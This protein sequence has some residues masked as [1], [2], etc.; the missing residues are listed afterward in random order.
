MRADTPKGFNPAALEVIDFLGGDRSTGMCFC[1][2]HDDGEKASLQVNNGDR[3]PVV[4]HCWGI[5]TKEH[6]LEVIAYLKAN[7]KWPTSS[8]LSRDQSSSQAEKARSPKKRRRYALQIWKE[9]RR[10]QR[11][12]DLRH[13]L[14]GYLQRRGIKNVPETALAVVPMECHEAEVA[15][16]DPGM[17][18]PVRNNEG[19]FQGIHVVWL[20]ADM[21]AKREAKP[22]RQSYG[23]LKGNFIQLTKIDWDNPPPKLIIAEGPETALAMTQFTGLPA[24]A[25][26]GKG[27]FAAVEPPR[28]SEYIIGVDNDDDGGSRK[29]AGE[30]AQRLVGCVVRIAM[31]DKPE[32]GKNGYD[33]ND[34]LID[35][36]A[37]EGKLA[38]LARSI[39]EAPSFEA[40]MTEVE[41]REGCINALAALK[42]ED[43]LAYEQERQQAANSLKI[44]LSIL[45]E[46]VDRRVSALKAQQ[47]TSPPSFNIDL[48][49]VSAREIIASEDVLAL[50][51]KEI[52]RLIVGEEKNAKILYLVATSRLFDKTM[53]A[54]VKGPSSGGKSEIRKRVL[55]FFPPEHVI[56]FTALSEHALLYMADDFAHKVLSM[57]EA[58]TGKQVEFQDYLLRELMS[59]G[60]LRYPVVQ[61]I[62]DELVTTMIEKDGPVSFLVTTTRNKLNPEN[63]TRMLSLEVNDTEEQTKAIL[64][65]VAAVVGLNKKA[66][67][68][69]LCR[70]HDYQRWLAAGECRVFIPYA[71]T[72][73]TLIKVTKSVRLRRDFSQLLIAIK[74]HALLHREHR[75]RSTKGSIVATIEE[76]YSA[77]RALMADLL[78]TASE[79]KMR[80]TIEDTIAAVRRVAA[81]RP[82]PD[83]DGA[84]VRQV[85]KEL[86]LDRSAV[87]RRLK[88][89]EGDGHIVNLESRK[90]YPARYK[91]S[92]DGGGLIDK[93]APGELLPTPGAL[94]RAYK[95][96]RSGAGGSAQPLQNAC[97]GAQEDG[98]G[99]ENQ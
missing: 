47:Q 85:A 52:G 20:N 99:I 10:L 21:T 42:L 54:A 19:K 25:T 68:D 96:A 43:H 73:S 63:E 17:V 69:E 50:F 16:H 56:S 24:I 95:A 70:W 11:D 37:D 55:D 46:E 35:A 5:G 12:R 92:D 34:A 48:L 78:A 45:D 90:G 6:D 15:A 67:T 76:D 97:T 36:G 1:P 3:G 66:R 2:C 57:G 32:G 18:L 60:K 23:L 71:K 89:A 65:K 62:Q 64:R 13:L 88:A 31:P 4:L 9:L 81:R 93:A 8:G 72:L 40:V 30:L 26:G 75:R 58:L 22:Q 29:A 7:K 39:M 77:V 44:R 94:R 84:T 14:A 49:A 91:P 51:A 74:A 53:H 28:C 80:E 87:H 59:E 98:E 79:I 27:F 33:W 38:K 83:L 41:K 61:K 86:N 82:D